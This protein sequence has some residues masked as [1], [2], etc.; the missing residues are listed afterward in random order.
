[1]A[2]EVQLDVGQELLD[3]GTVNVVLAVTA[4]HTLSADAVLS[5]YDLAAPADPLPEIPLATAIFLAAPSGA[6]ETLVLQLPVTEGGITVHHV[7]L[8]LGGEA[9]LA[10]E[11]SFTLLAETSSEMLLP[12]L[13]IEVL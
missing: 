6:V 10:G 11:V 1:M 8:A 3:V 12:P 7:V 2:F 4:A 9:D 13:V 5:L